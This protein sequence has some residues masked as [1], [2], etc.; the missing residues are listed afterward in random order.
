MILTDPFD[1]GAEDLLMDAWATAIA[2]LPTDGF[3]T[4]PGYGHAYSG[5]GGRPRSQPTFET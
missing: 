4:A 1:Y 3:A 2:G 5:P